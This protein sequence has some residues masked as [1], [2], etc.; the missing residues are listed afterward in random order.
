MPNTVLLPSFRRETGLATIDMTA[1]FRLTP[2]DASEGIAVLGHLWTLT[3]GDTTLACLVKTHPL[4]W[5]ARMTIDEM[6]V[7]S[8][9]SQEP[10]PILATGGAWCAL[11]VS[12]GWRP[13]AS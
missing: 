6:F 7:R 5:E 11:A 1:P 2:Y 13:A 10:A 4:G 3:K 9:V 8:E 12:Q